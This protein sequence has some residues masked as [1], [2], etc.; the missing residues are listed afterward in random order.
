MG[1]N[2]GT[3]AYPQ[4]LLP[5][6]LI[7][8]IKCMIL[9]PKSLAGLMAQPVGPPNPKPIPPTNRATGNADNDPKSDPAYFRK[10][11][12]IKNSMVAKVSVMKFWGKLRIEGP[13]LKTA[14]LADASLHSIK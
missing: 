12:P 11:I 10:K 7:G 6:P 2:T 3:A 14:N 9:G 1:P 5:F 4:S 13:V 8:R